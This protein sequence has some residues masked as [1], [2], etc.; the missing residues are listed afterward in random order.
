[1]AHF[2]IARWYERLGDFD[3]AFQ[4]YQTANAIK[5]DRSDGRRRRVRSVAE[6]GSDPFAELKRVF[7]PT[8]FD[9][10]REWGNSS[11]LPVFIVGM[12]RSGTTLVEQ[13][14]AGHS[15]VHGAGELSDITDLTLSLPRRLALNQRYPE[16]ARELTEGM[17]ASLTA[18]YLTQ[19][20]R[21][22]ESAIRVTDKCRPTSGT[23]G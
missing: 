13:I 22:A 4:H 6:S 7:Q 10:R 12:P 23:W 9:R 3:T 5:Q 19:L 15:A 20:Q 21:R 16:A 11:E 14:L 17:A 18:E 2:A 1:M 8:F